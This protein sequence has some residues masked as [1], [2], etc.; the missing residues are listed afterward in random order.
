VSGEAALQN[1]VVFRIPA[2]PKGRLGI[3]KV[4]FGNERSDAGQKRR[5]LLSRN[6]L[7]RFKLNGH[8]SVLVQQLWGNPNFSLAECARNRCERFSTE[9]KSGY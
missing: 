6:L 1:H 4:S 9:S 3:A 5:R 8:L 2:D 7:G